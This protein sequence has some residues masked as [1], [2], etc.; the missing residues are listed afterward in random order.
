MLFVLSK[1]GTPADSSIYGLTLSSLL[2]TS[3]NNHH[4]RS[5]SWYN[6]RINYKKKTALSLVIY[7]R[8]NHRDIKA[9]QWSEPVQDYGP[10]DV[11]HSK[12]AT[13]IQKTNMSV[14]FIFN[15]N[16]SI[17][18]HRRLLWDIKRHFAHKAFKSIGTYWLIVCENIENRCQQ[19]RQSVGEHCQWNSMIVE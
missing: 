9:F 10:I 2:D 19:R 15:V 18:L 3:V 16:Y 6:C 11:G 1:H 5:I 7:C 17:T 13:A 14:F 12:I 4:N 8:I